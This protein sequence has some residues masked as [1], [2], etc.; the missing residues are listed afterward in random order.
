MSAGAAQ[1]SAALPLPRRAQ[2]PPRKTIRLCP[3]ALRCPWW[4]DGALAQTVV[5]SLSAEPDHTERSEPLK[6]PLEGS[7]APGSSCTRRGACWQP[8]PAWVETEPGKADSCQE[9]FPQ[10]SIWTRLLLP[11]TKT[12]PSAHPEGS[13]I[14]ELCLLTR[15]AGS[16]TVEDIEED[17]QA[18]K[19]IERCL[20]RH[21]VP[22]AHRQ[23]QELPGDAQ[24]KHSPRC[25]APVRSLS[26]SQALR[27]AAT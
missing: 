16:A 24:A 9:P 12:Q 13:G 21:P 5:F 27:G 3:G 1:G 10:L 22:A 4:Q 23:S 7:Q 18:T 17:I 20:N 11:G 15:A 19:A 25:L 14:P 6:T 26:L 8:A 2:E